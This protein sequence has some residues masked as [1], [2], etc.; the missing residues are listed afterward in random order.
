MPQQLNVNRNDNR[1]LELS[2]FMQTQ[3][4]GCLSTT[5]GRD[6]FVAIVFYVVEDDRLYFKSRTGSNHSKH[7]QSH[8]SASFGVYEKNSSYDAKYG[9]QL[10]GNVSR[11]RDV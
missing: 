7:L 3:D 1:S 5:D 4:I 11:V 8:S 6:S 9:A 10:L 2:T